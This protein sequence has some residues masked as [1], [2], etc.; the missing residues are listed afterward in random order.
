MGVHSGIS[1]QHDGAFNKPGVIV[2]NPHVKI[3]V[4]NMT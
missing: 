4:V 3:D 1:S 2:I